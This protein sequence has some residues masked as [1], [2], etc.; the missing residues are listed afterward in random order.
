MRESQ[1]AWAQV[2]QQPGFAAAPRHAP[3]YLALSWAEVT[4]NDSALGQPANYRHAG[5]R[6]GAVAE[7]HFT[8]HHLSIRTAAGHPAQLVFTP[9]IFD[10]S[11]RYCT[12]AAARTTSP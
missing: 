7:T 5:L 6:Y 8:L 4:Q 2:Q 11:P 10:N 12:V 9:E 1:A 3:V